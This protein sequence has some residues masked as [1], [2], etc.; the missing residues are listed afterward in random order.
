MEYR[1][2]AGHVASDSNGRPGVHGANGANRRRATVTL[3]EEELATRI[4]REVGEA[5]R[6]TEQRAAA[7]V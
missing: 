2:M 4:Q 7:G 3:T 6:Q 1:D 5:T